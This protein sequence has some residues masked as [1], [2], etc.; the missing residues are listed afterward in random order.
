M[1]TELEK[2]AI[3]K[4]STLENKNGFQEDVREYSKDSS[5]VLS[6][7]TGKGMNLSGH[8]HSLP[9]HS[10]GKN[11]INYSNFNTKDGGQAQ[12]RTAR[13]TQTTRALYDE[14]HPYGEQLID[15]SANIGQY[16]VTP[17]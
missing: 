16:N 3:A 4:R 7:G 5:T 1:Q 9:D 8:G 11:T 2:E 17:V 14:N 13:T 6:S 12:D 15:T 10:L